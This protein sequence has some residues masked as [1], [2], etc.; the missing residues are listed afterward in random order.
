MTTAQCIEVLKQ[1][2]AWRRDDD[3]EHEILPGALVGQA[4]DHAI[5]Y[6]QAAEKLRK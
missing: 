6:M 3:G 1:H 4:I 5:A 2:N